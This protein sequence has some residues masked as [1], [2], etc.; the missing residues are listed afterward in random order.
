MF[1][2][3]ERESP[4]WIDLWDLAVVKGKV[5]LPFDIWLH[6]EIILF[7]PTLASWCDSLNKKGPKELYERRQQQI[8]DEDIYFI[9]FLYFLGSTTIQWVSE[10]SLNTIEMV[11]SPVKVSKNTLIVSWYM[12]VLIWYFKASTMVSCF[13]KFVEVQCF[14]S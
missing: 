5:V 13:W 11:E 6:Y 9:F 14:S 7:Y 10:F 3:W 2:Y 4:K 12:L 8:G 1:F